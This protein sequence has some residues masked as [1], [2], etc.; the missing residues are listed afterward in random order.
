VHLRDTIIIEKVDEDTRRIGPT[1]KVGGHDL[2]LM[3]EVGSPGGQTILPKK[4]KHLKFFNKKTGQ[5]EFR[6]QVQRG[7]RG[8]LWWV[9]DAFQRVLDPIRS[10]TV[11]AFREWYE[12]NATKDF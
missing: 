8:P 1:K 7:F 11:N 9:R 3:L 6:C 10:L 4:G 12:K 5:I 2:G